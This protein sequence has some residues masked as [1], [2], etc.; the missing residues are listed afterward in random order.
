MLES[1]SCRVRRKA[2]GELLLLVQHREKIQT[3]E[4]P[5]GAFLPPK[6]D[7]VRPKGDGEGTRGAHP[8]FGVR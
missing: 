6:P 8:P 1:A 2:L 5:N 7:G 4:N 3:E